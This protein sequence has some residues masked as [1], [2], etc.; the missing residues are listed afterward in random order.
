ME[1][2]ISVLL[3]YLAVLSLGFNISISMD[4]FKVGSLN[5]NG[6]RDAKKRV[7]LYET[8]KLKK[9]LFVQETHS[10]TDNET[11]WVR[12]WDGKILLSHGTTASAGVGLLFSRT[13]NP[14]SV[15]AEHVVQGKCL[16]IRAA[17]EH[18]N[19]VF[20]NIYAPSVGAERK[21]FLEKVNEK[22]KDFNSSD[23]VFLGGDFNCTENEI[24]DRNHAEPHPVSQH[25]LQQLVRSHG[26]VD[27]WRRMHTAPGS[28]RGPV[29]KI[30][31]SL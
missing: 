24:L 12:E 31:G 15:E 18:F 13:F 14:L 28:L 22:L 17:F 11:D 9:V 26:L 27:N 7:F 5:L 21:R 20:I 2:N 6:A 16:L 3:I 19:I 1:V 4:T 10:D 29:V 30:T 8:A 23:Y 25:A